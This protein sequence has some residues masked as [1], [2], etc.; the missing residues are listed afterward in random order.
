LEVKADERAAAGWKPDGSATAG[1]GACPPRRRLRCWWLPV[2][3]G[4]AF[5]HFRPAWQSSHALVL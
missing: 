4:R 5:R 3:F 1:C 2:P